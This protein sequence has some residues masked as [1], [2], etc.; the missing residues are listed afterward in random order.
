MTNWSTLFVAAAILVAV[1]VPLVAQEGQ[2]IPPEAMKAM[3][4]GE[5]H[6][7]LETL[8]GEYNMSGKAWMV[9]GA[10]PT[11]FTGTRT[12]KMILGGRFLEEKVDSQFM[13]MPFEG[14]G[15]FAYDNVAERYIYTWVDNMGTTVTSAYGNCS[16]DGVW[17]LEGEHIDPVTGEMSSYRN[18]MRTTDTGFVFEWHEKESMMMEITYTKK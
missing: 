13:G 11:E 6:K 18:I 8:A 1:A 14:R 17:T 15:L 16:A 10:E 12:A 5:H 3:M 7:H 4:P 9:P 2:D